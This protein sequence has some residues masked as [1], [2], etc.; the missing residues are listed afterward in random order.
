MSIPT[1]YDKLFSYLCQALPEFR[2]T[3]VRNLALW[4]WGLLRAGHCA[5]GRVADQLPIAGTKESRIRR[6]KRWLLNPRVVVDHMYGPLVRMTLSR[7][8][9]LEVTL[10]L[11]RTEWGKFNVLLVGIALLGRVLPLAWTVLSHQGNSDFAEQKALL[12][13]VRPWLPQAPKKGILG[14][15][16]FKSVALMRYA[17]SLGWDFGLGQSAD[18][19]F[20][21][22]S[23][24]WQ[25]LGDLKVSKE[26]PLY[27][28]GISLT[29]EHAFGPVNLIAYW[30]RAKKTQRYVATCRPASRSTFAWGRQRSWIEGTFRDDKSGGFN[31]EATHLENPDRL[32]RLLLVIAVAYLWS[33]HVGRW[34]VKTGQR[35]WMDAAKQRTLSYFRL[36]FD[37]LRRTITLGHP[38]KI[39]FAVYT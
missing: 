17:L 2:V 28:S 20:R 35:R 36:G 10:V 3:Q 24:S 9:R 39:G 5:L 34:V 15:G 8:H 23:G 21:D 31:L 13:R 33:F 32:N 37:W 25:R 29:Q 1:S 7:W 27:L 16:E 4:V 38:L 6:L 14:D 18:T 30:D 19:L 22:S 12:E 26:H 11:D